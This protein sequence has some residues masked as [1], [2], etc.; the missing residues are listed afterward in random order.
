MDPQVLK[1][2]KYIPLVGAV[3]SF[4]FEFCH[5]D[6]LSEFAD[7]LGPLL[8]QGLWGPSHSPASP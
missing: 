5:Q 1:I 3:K 2:T 6:G 7:V 4:P 8:C